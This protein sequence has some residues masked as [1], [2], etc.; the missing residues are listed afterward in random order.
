MHAFFGYDC[1]YNEFLNDTEKHS[2]HSN[3]T[4]TFYSNVCHEDV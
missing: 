3:T 2:V 4:N 1:T